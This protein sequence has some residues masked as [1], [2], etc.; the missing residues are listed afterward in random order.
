MILPFS[1]VASGKTEMKGGVTVL[2]SCHSL[3]YMRAHEEHCGAQAVK[4]TRIE[5]PR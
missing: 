1:I 2:I 3:L 4:T 5:S